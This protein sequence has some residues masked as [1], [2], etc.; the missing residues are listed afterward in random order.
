MAKYVTNNIKAAI[1]N[2]QH[3]RD[4]QI[5]TNEEFCNATDARGVDYQANRDLLGKVFVESLSEKT[6]KER[7]FHDKRGHKVIFFNPFMLNKAG[8]RIYLAIRAKGVHSKTIR[9]WITRAGAR[10]GIKVLFSKEGN[11]G[12]GGWK[13]VQKEW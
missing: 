4:T 3:Q 11:P 8:Q 1:Q 13:A 12:R 5:Q 9:Q 7:V 2:V 6:Q 10:E